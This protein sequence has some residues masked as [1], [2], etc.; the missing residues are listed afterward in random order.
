MATR[1]AQAKRVS[2]EM[3]FVRLGSKDARGG[4]SNPAKKGNHSPMAYLHLGW[5]TTMPLDE[6]NRHE[7]LSTQSIVRPILLRALKICVQLRRAA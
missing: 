7:A 6:C 2:H 3:W 1:F 4:G 5:H